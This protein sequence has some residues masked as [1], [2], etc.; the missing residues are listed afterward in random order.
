MN[1]N[2]MECKRPIKTNGKRCWPKK[3]PAEEWEQKCLHVERKRTRQWLRSAGIKAEKKNLFLLH[4]INYCP[5]GIINEIF[6]LMKLTLNVEFVMNIGKP[7]I[8]LSP[9]ILC[10]LQSSIKLEMI[11]W[12]NICAEKY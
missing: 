3:Q 5:P 2:K 4:R 12:D 8:A 9:D 6:W 7:F 10:S 11:F 1:S